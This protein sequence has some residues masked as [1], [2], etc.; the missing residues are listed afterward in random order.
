MSEFAIARYNMVESQ[1]RPNRVTDRR[2][3]EAMLEIPREKF[4]PASKRPLAYMDEEIVFETPGKAASD[5]FMIAPMTLAQLIQLAEIEDGNVVLDIGC[6]TGYSSVILARLA[7]AV[8]G[9]ECD[10]ELAESASANIIEL[11]ADNAAIVSGDLAEGYPDEGPYDAIILQGSVP[12]VP[13][14]LLAQLKEGGRLVAIVGD[15]DMGQALLYRNIGGEFPA[16]FA[17]DA[18]APRLPGFEQT[19][20]FVF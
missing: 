14:T 3:L 18:A 13:R 15:K 6:T 10:S 9:L 20:E 2:I 16:V 19:P 8:V 4:V 17:F 1:I 5:R 12:E 11:E 7:G